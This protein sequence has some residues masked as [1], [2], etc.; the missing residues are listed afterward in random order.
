MISTTVV[1][2]PRLL[3]G[4]C[5]GTF[6]YRPEGLARPSV[7]A[8]LTTGL[9]EGL[10]GEQATC[11]LQAFCF[12]VSPRQA[13]RLAF[14]GFPLP[15]VLFLWLNC[16]SWTVGD[17]VYDMYLLDV[18]RFSMLVSYISSSFTLLLCSSPCPCSTSR[19]VRCLRPRSGSHHHRRHQLRRPRRQR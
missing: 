8:S 6:P 3:R 10:V 14:W 13:S 19:S 7:N 9:Y 15:F 18:F 17:L 12:G 4:G 2:F 1:P 16:V 5:H 11:F